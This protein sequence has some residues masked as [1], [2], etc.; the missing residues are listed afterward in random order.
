MTTERKTVFKSV[1]KAEKDRF[2]INP[3][4][5]FPGASD[6]LCLVRE[7]WKAMT[8]VV[9]WHGLLPQTSSVE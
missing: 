8:A 6:G 7:S 9:A 1:F 5:L 4:P 2:E 3:K